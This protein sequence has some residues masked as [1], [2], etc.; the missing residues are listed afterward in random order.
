MSFQSRANDQLVFDRQHN[1]NVN[2][3]FA[4]ERCRSKTKNNIND[5][6]YGEAISQSTFYD[7]NR[8]QYGSFDDIK[9]IAT[10]NLHR[11]ELDR[12]LSMQ[13]NNPN[14]YQ[15]AFEYPISERPSDCYSLFECSSHFLQQT[16]P[17]S[18][19]LD[20]TLDV[21][22]DKYQDS[23][24]PS[25]TIF[26]QKFI[27]KSSIEED[28]LMKAKIIELPP[29][30]P[31]D[32]NAIGLT[33]KTDYKKD[34]YP[35]VEQFLQNFKLSNDTDKSPNNNDEFN[36]MDTD[37]NFFNYSTSIG[38]KLLKMFEKIHP[39]PIENKVDE[40]NDQVVKQNLE[41][42]ANSALSVAHDEGDLKVS[43]ILE[44]KNQAEPD[45]IG[46]DRINENKEN[47]PKCEVQKDE[48]KQHAK[49]EDK[50]NSFIVVDLPRHDTCSTKD[51]ISTVQK[52]IKKSGTKSKITMR[53]CSD[54]VRSMNKCETDYDDMFDHKKLNLT[55]RSFKLRARKN[56]SLLFDNI[57]NSE[58]GTEKQ[59]RLESGA[60]NKKVDT[61]TFNEKY[62]NE[63]Q[64]AAEMAKVNNENNSDSKDSKHIQKNID[65]SDNNN[66]DFYIRKIEKE[67]YNITRPYIP[68]E[69]TKHRH[70]TILQLKEIHVAPILDNNDQM[71]KKSK[72]E[73]VNIDKIDDS[74]KDEH[75][76]NK[77]IETEM[78]TVII[79]VKT[80]VKENQSKNSDLNN[81]TKKSAEN[82]RDQ[83]ISGTTKKRNIMS[84][85]NPVASCKHDSKKQN[86]KEEKHDLQQ[87]SKSNAQMCEK[88][89]L[90]AQRSQIKFGK[91]DNKKDSQRHARQSEAYRKYS[92]NLDSEVKKEDPIDKESK[93]EDPN[94]DSSSS[95]D[96]QRHKR[97]LRKNRAYK[98]RHQYQKRLKWKTCKKNK[99][100]K[101]NSEKE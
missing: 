65:S 22:E 76:N 68:L 70:N 99:H 88:Q 27:E 42:E 2:E 9:D 75:T 11:S 19:N 41:A 30:S 83:L 34:I 95:D 67:K 49:R 1:E 24:L 77:K 81:I 59:T 26:N 79:K 21:G 78:E 7:S 63:E 91:N 97:K 101:S 10:V 43:D 33:S 4:T 46:T 53:H 31:P 14:I 35:V 85:S 15:S 51:R 39:G 74:Q 32:E 16:L 28:S 56:Y 13:S 100:S 98:H 72:C 57:I 80:D 61:R 58:F 38:E 47:L 89:N 17:K 93:Q 71:I 44:N 5:I 20:F 6:Y 69:I 64:P 86:I 37:S 12:R 23:F 3:T 29:D 50:V 87:A 54:T 73:S 62:E 25:L 66:E 8:K 60:V 18:D 40:P 45:I 82:D 55:P 36:K 48:V 96:D 84:L 52:T 94:S 90:E 92:L